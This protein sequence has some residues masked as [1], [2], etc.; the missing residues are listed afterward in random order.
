[1]PKTL[2]GNYTVQIAL[3]TQTG[4]G[5]LTS[6]TVVPVAY[7]EFDRKAAATPSPKTVRP[8]QELVLDKQEQSLNDGWPGPEA[9]RAVVKLYPEK[10]RLRMAAQVCDA[11]FATETPERMEWEA[12]CVELFVSATGLDK[13]LVHVLAVP[14]GPE[15]APRMRGYA[16]NAPDVDLAGLTGSWKRTGGG[17]DMEV[18]I[19]WS[20]LPHYSKDSRFIAMEAAVD[21]EVPFGLCQLRLN[22]TTAPQRGTAG[23]SRL[24]MK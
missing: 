20:K 7:P 24:M 14:E 19:P 10:E 22:S 5:I 6:Q 2:K 1:V 9:L 4:L 3:D 23:F 12:S 11:R 8:G 13:D 15:N 21:T 16:V 18:A 17:Y